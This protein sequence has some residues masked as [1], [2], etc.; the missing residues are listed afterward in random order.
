MKCYRCGGTMQ[1][2]VTDLPF[3]TQKNSTVIIKNL[4]VLQ[5]D[6]C[7]EFELENEAMN[8]VESKINSVDNSAELEIIKYAV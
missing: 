2:I 1:R 8:Y 4:P 6:T 3:K 7:R 5:C